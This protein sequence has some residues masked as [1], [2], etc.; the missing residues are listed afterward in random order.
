MSQLYEFIWGLEVTPW[1]TLRLCTNFQCSGGF[2]KMKAG[3]PQSLESKKVHRRGEIEIKEHP[4]N[5]P[6][7]SGFQRYP[8]LQNV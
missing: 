4:K 3:A 5:R 2:G 6:F 8:R 7:D 1:E